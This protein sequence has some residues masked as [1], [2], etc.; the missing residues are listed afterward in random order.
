[1]AV[2]LVLEVNAEWPYRSFQDAIAP[3]LS[4]ILDSPLKIRL[5][6][7]DPHDDLPRRGFGRALYRY[8]Q[9]KGLD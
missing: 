3:F 5:H 1:M 6:G 8:V 4:P 9:L 7:C 2:E